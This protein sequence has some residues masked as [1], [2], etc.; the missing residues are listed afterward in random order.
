[1]RPKQ[2]LIAI[3]SG[4]DTDLEWPYTKLRLP[5]ERYNS[6]AKANSSGDRRE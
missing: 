6:N 1:L 5:K 4:A 3:R 2:R